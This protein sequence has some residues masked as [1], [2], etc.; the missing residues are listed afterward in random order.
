MACPIYNTKR[1]Y[2]NPSDKD[3]LRILV[4]RLWPRGGLVKNEQG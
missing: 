4:D 3:G 1:I 2:E